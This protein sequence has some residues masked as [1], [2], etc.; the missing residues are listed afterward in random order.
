MVLKKIF[1]KKK[2]TPKYF[3]EVEVKDQAPATP[4]QEKAPTSENNQPEGK[5]PTAKK[6]APAPKATSNVPAD[7]PEWV[8]AIKNYSN[9]GDSESQSG[10]DDSTFAG[11]YVTNNVPQARRRP[12]GSLKAFKN[13]AAQINK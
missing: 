13:I 6:T 1:S 11:K 12:G 10:D 7:Q 4:A 9:T 2:G 5:Q 8:K 3:L